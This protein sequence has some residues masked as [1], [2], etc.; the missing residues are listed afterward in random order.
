MTQIFPPTPHHALDINS[1][2]AWYI[3]KSDIFMVPLSTLERKK[4]DGG[5]DLITVD[6]KCRALFLHHL[7][8]QC[9][10]AG[11]PTL[12]WMQ[13]WNL[14]SSLGNPPNPFGISDK[15]NIYEYSSRTPRTFL[16]KV[17]LNRQEHIRDVYTQRY[18]TYPLLN[19]HHRKC[20]WSPYG[21]MQTGSESGRI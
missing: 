14:D 3:W 9:Q 12:D 6:A 13:Y 11:S 21:R 1:A 8:M 20:G 2:I 7:Q 15:L 18:E 17:E 19:R 16:D 10:R 4:T 5:W